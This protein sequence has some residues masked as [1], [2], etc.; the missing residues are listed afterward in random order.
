[1]GYWLQCISAGNGRQFFAGAGPEG[2]ERNSRFG[3]YDDT[4]LDFGAK[5][6]VAVVKVPSIDKPVLVGLGPPAGK[7]SASARPFGHD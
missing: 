5:W 3:S 4:T 1:M 6:G 2:L 7:A